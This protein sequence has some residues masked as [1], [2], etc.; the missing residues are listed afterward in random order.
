LADIPRKLQNL[1]RLS[2][3]YRQSSNLHM[4]ADEV[5]ISI[6]V[7]LERIVDRLS[8]RFGGMLI[9]PAVAQRAMN[10]VAN[11]VS[12]KTLADL[13]SLRKDSLKG[14]RSR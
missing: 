9:L 2:E 4:F 13:L 6:F 10:A 3:V 8:M 14:K 12:N 5:F 1:Q 11:D 7:I